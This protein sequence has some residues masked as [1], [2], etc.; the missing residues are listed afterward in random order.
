MRLYQGS[1]FTSD[2]SKNLTNDNGIKLRLP[3]VKAH[4]SLGIGELHSLLIRIYN[5]IANKLPTISMQLVLRVAA[6]AKNDTLS[7]NGLMPSRLV[8]GII[9]R[10]P[11]HNTD[12]TNQ[13]E[14]MTKTS[15]AQAEK[16]III[17]ERRVLAALNRSIP[18][19]ADRV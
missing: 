15:K 8:F 13:R 9:S 10:P 1:A 18:P 3:S 19:V 17:A 6:K 7:E 4:S 16:N 11:V 12:L 5:K 2:K 14:R